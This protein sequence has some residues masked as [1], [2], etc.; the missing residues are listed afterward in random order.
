MMDLLSLA[1][2][3]GGLVLTIIGCALAYVGHWLWIPFV[4]CGVG[5]SLARLLFP[6]ETAFLT[7]GLAIVFGSIALALFSLLYHVLGYP[8]SPVVWYAGLSLLVSGISVFGIP[9]TVTK[10]FLWDRWNHTLLLP[11]VVLLCLI[12]AVMARNGYVTLP[13]GR[14]QVFLRGYHNGDTATLFALTLRAQQEGTLSRA[15]PFAAGASLEYPTLLHGTI[16]ILLSTVDGDITRIAWWLVPF[17]VFGALAVLAVL[18]RRM[19]PGMSPWWVGIVLAWVLAFSVE[20]Y[21]YPQSHTFLM[22]PFVACMLC[23]FL[24]ER[25]RG[26]RRWTLW[27][28]GILT[29]L[30]LIFSN[31]ILGTA[32]LA[33]VLLSAVFAFHRQTMQERIASVVAHGTLLFLFFLFPPGNGGLG[34]LNVPYTI[35]PD[36]FMIAVP[37]FMIIFLI[38]RHLEFASLST[39]RAIALG[40]PLLTVIT[41]FFSRRGIV[42][43]NAARFLSLTLLVLW[44]ASV[45]WLQDIIQDL[46]KHVRLTNPIAIVCILFGCFIVL[47]P[48]AVSIARAAESLLLSKP[49]VVTA[50]DLSAFRWIRENTAPSA[51][52]VR[53]PG[54]T[55]S[56]ALALPMFTGRSLLRSDFWLSPDDALAE[57]QRQALATG[58]VNDLP[59]DYLFCESTTTDCLRGENA[60]FSSGAV[61]IQTLGLP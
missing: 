52:F 21:I 54:R 12:G 27:C 53:V 44:P 11:G 47:L 25:E 19:I 33:V 41:M 3:F 23:L 31:A 17:A 57:T 59:A 37:V 45:P 24:A 26:S 46:R 9:K 8:A 5:W 34:G 6:E 22:G 1:A 7:A 36:V 32:A 14:E 61:Q 48:P 28:A 20:A 18:A 15:N 43:E 40:L 39:V 42:A 55:D 58:R 4:L 13:D 51:V 30:V 35:F 49:S 60:S 50:D 29:A 16:G 56:A 38:R 10:V 2:R